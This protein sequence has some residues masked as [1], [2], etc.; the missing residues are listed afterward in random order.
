[1]EIRKSMGR[2]LSIF[3][4]VALGVSLFVG[5][6]ATKPD[7]ILSGDA[8]VDENKLMDIKVVS[9]YGLTEEDMAAIEK[10]PAIETVEGAYSVDV[11]CEAGEN[12]KVLHLMSRTENMNSVTV[13]KGR[14]PKKATE[15]LVDEDFLETSEYEIGDMIEV[16]SGTDEEL[17]DTLKNTSFKIVGAGNSPLYFSLDRGSSTIGNGSISGFMLVA[18]KAFTLDVYTEVYAMVKGAEDALS[19]TEEYDDLVEEATWQIEMIQNMRCEVRKDDLAAQAQLEIDNAR[20]ELNEKKK[21]AESE[22][23][24]NEKKLEEAEIDIK[25]GK[26][27]LE[28][29]KTS[30]KSGKTELEAGRAEYEQ[31][32]AEY[33]SGKAEYE[34]LKTLIE[35]GK[36]EL[37]SGKAELAAGKTALAEKSAP[38]DQTIDSLQRKKNE[39]EQQIQVLQGQLVIAAPEQVVA[40]QMQISALQAKLLEVDTQLQAVTAQREQFFGEAEREL[41][42][43]EKLLQEKETELLQAEKELAPAEKE[44]ASAE[45][46]L[47]NAEQEMLKGEQEI[48]KSEQTIANTE[49]ELASGEKKIQEGKQELENARQE[50]ETQI[51]DGET[52]IKDAQEDIS[53]L[54]LPVWYVFDRSSIPE[55]TGYGDNADRID[56]LS[57]VFPS[58][59]FLVAALISLTTMTRMVEEQRVQ[60]GTLKALGYSKFA[61][62]KKYLNYAM[63]ATFGGSIFGVLVGEK[64]FP[65]VIIVAYKI[66]YIHIPHVIL[67]YQ[68]GHGVM[69]TLIAVLCTGAATIFA[70]YKELLAQPAILMRPEAP[71]IGKRTLIEKIPFVWK[72]LS[73]TWKSSLR[74]L[75]RYKKRF[76]M[77]LFGIGGCMGLLMVGYGLRDSITSVGTY[78]YDD[79]QTYDA[80]VFIAEEMQGAAREELTSY[81]SENDRIAA[82]TNV[83][84]SS[85]TTQND[86]D[87]VDAYLTVIDDVEQV[88]TFFTYR[89]R[90]SKEKY[91]LGNKG[92][93]L[94][95]KTA[96]M[97]NVGVGDAILISEEGKNEQKV[98]ITA[99]CENYAGHYVYLTS[100]LYEKLY[101]KE[102]FYNNILI[103][104]DKGTTYETLQAVGEEILE[105]ENILN[106]QYTADLSTQLND[107]LVALDQVMI[108]LIVVAGMLSF[109]V[110]YNLNNI[111]ITERR[112]E[113]ATLKVLGFYDIEVAEYVYREN[114]MLTLLGA[115]VGCGIG[116]FLH[117]FTIKTVEVDAAMFGRDIFPASYLISA[118]ITIGFS[119]FVNWIMYFKLK[120]I[121][122][123]ESLK[124]VE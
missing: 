99:I 34:N 81:L 93:I 124:S 76:F 28:S 123:V 26:A 98:E 106:V 112:R 100:T 68:W 56:A 78:Q 90:V 63:L 18:P 8:Y 95:E 102:P 3:F 103:K 117:L 62:M 2:F 20:A 70:C 5:I 6:R 110:L 37:E 121:N 105:Y 58:I 38:L 41:A 51:A 47:A 115:L 53:E 7:M 19:F 77:T 15:C 113:L 27:Q 86:D 104:A 120:K 60:I 107:M 109:V 46:G 4:I 12:M 114:M 49:K 71:K 16:V 14:L 35:E 55:Y 82:Y 45:Q 23:A 94:T 119:A 84:M 11:L 116:R 69:A 54:E 97:L 73:F 67:P 101:N 30:L 33:E 66:M 122:M 85:I 17:T 48:S 43:S 50:M 57:I 72:H 118:L 52:E 96:D 21:D 36:K 80:S 64:L 24:E 61:I 39:L 10:L 13:T 108:V 9:T 75:F 79:L 22:I 91:K 59:F 74:N 44:L 65:Y 92:V 1:M 87:E 25:I 40:L 42:A 83:H 29:G 32:K 31:G 88:E 111:N 89:D